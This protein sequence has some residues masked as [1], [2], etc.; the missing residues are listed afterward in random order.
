MSKVKAFEYLKNLACC[1]DEDIGTDNDGND[2]GSDDFD[3]YDGG[4][5]V[6]DS[7]GYQVAD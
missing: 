1:D 5:D 6:L 3:V 2:D 4:D 7:L